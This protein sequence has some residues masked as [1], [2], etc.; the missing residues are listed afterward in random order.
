MI[1][2]NVYKKIRKL[3]KI[4]TGQDEPR[5]LD[6]SASTPKEGVFRSVNI[7]FTRVEPKNW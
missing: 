7:I 3:L 6:S 1:K 2:E 5:H 4:L